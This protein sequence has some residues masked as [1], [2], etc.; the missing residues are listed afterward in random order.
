MSWFFGPARSRRPDAIKEITSNRDTLQQRL[1]LTLAQGQ[2]ARTEA[3][4]CARKGDRSSALLHL[5]LSKAKVALV[6]MSLNLHPTPHCLKGCAM[7]V[8]PNDLTNVRMPTRGLQESEASQ[9]AS[10]RARAEKNIAALQM[11]ELTSMARIL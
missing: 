1:E 6:A 8:R 10:L 4:F 9:I 7:C 2:A 11:H 5:Q 3:Q